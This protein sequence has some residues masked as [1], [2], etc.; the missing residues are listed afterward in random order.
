M[1]LW[2]RRVGSL[3][4]PPS[5]PGTVVVSRGNSAY[6]SRRLSA[7]GHDPAPPPARPRNQPFL[8]QVSLRTG[9]SLP[10]NASGRRFLGHTTPVRSG[11]SSW[12]GTPSEPA[13]SKVPFNKNYLPRT[14]VFARFLTREFPPGNKTLVRQTR[15]T[16]HWS[17]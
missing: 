10:G 4:L 11:S 12:P 8:E 6:N 14:F 13:P 5:R 3:S 16:V 2:S 17:V 7:R 1:G 9:T 15:L